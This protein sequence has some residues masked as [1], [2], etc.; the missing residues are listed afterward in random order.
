MKKAV[1]P[2][3]IAAAVFT[4][5]LI[6]QRYTLICQEYDG[7]FLAVPDYFRQLFRKPLP[8]SHL[9]TDFIKIFLDPFAPAVRCKP[10]RFEIIS[11]FS[12]CSFV[13][14]RRKI[15]FSVMK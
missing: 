2:L 6:A 11:C 12:P 13:C 14:V 4:V 9:V 8:L 7:L 10:F 3:L 1:T 5:S 15:P